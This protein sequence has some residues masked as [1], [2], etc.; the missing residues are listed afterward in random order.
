VG[1]V[2]MSLCRALVSEL[3]QQPGP[4]Q[5]QIELPYEELY[6]N[7]YRNVFDIIAEEEEEE[8]RDSREGGHDGHDKD[9]LEGVVLDIR[10]AAHEHDLDV[11]WVDR[12][13]TLKLV[14]DR[15]PPGESSSMISY[16]GHVMVF[17]WSSKRDSP[18]ASD[19]YYF[20]KGEIGSPLLPQ[21]P[22]VPQPLPFSCL[23]P[24]TPPQP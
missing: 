23:S 12:Y 21:P 8:K 5:R 9:E 19:L 10:N 3:G 22:L 6:D 1:V 18:L 11:F 4:G 2:L 13:S 7:N 24:L 14:E 20:T 16:A 17:Q 15:I